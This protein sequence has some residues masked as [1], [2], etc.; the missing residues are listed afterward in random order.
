M[1]SGGVA[2]NKGMN[3]MQE[4]LSIKNKSCSASRRR[5]APDIE[6]SGAPRRRDAPDIELSGAPRRRDAVA[7]TQSGARVG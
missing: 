5:D 2:K 6:L 3:E 4:T 7:V 1:I